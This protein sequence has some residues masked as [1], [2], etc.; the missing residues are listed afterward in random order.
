MKINL[1][2]VYDEPKRED[3]LRVLVDRLW[4][5]G[6]AK[7]KAKLNQWM[8]EVAPSDELRKWF[9][10]D[11]RKWKDFQNKY[12]GE[13]KSKEEL[14]EKIKHAE[15][16]KRIVT[17]LYSAKD[18]QHNNAVALREILERKRAPAH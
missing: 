4:P 12:Q 13:L 3:G 17:L 14:I 1:K 7:E 2:R 8:K 16:E 11:P 9:A 10:H 18:E 5:R 6:L 15:K